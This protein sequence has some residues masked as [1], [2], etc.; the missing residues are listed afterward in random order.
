VASYTRDKTQLCG[1]VPG[2]ES[3]ILEGRYRTTARSKAAYIS[4]N[5]PA[6]LAHE[7]CHQATPQRGALHSAAG[8]LQSNFPGTLESIQSDPRPRVAD[9]PVSVG[10]SCNA[11]HIHTLCVRCQEGSCSTVTCELRLQQCLSFACGGGGSGLASALGL[12][13]LLA[14]AQLVREPGA[15][16]AGCVGH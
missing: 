10:Q 15:A 13:D 12:L 9:D 6:A 11:R 16:D 1:A 14:V 8:R 5:N 7:G 2:L 4:K 3:G